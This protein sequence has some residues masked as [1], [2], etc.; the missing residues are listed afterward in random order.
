MGSAFVHLARLDDIKNEAVLYS[1]YTAS[2]IVHS[3]GFEP[4][5]H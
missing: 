4:W 5:T 3:Q 2:T 1:I